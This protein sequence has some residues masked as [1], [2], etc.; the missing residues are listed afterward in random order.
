M[1]KTPD[2]LP[3]AEELAPPIVL[4]DGVC[5]LCNHSVNFIIDRDP[6]RTIRFASL[7]SPAGQELLVRFGLPTDQL[8]SMVLIEGD[9]TF[10]RS[11][12]ALRIARHMRFP[13]PLVFALI[14]IPPPIRNLFYDLL[15]HNRYRWFGKSE[16]CRI[17][18]PELRERF[19]G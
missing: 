19:L 14:V 2:P 4:F 18:T 9:R 17:P 11:S 13:W 12:A 15:A 5:N 8:S 3:A 10:S 6:R 16:T 7:Q 1:K